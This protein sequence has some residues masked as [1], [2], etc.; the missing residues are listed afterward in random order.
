MAKQQ[1]KKERKSYFRTCVVSRSK[2]TPSLLLR[3][4]LDKASRIVSFDCNHNLKGRGAYVLRENLEALL[5]R[6]LLNRSFK[7]ELSREDY[8]RLYKEVEI[9]QRREE[10]TT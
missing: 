7:M 5:R 2:H 10:G 8:D 6:K 3:F 1:L 9:C 4:N